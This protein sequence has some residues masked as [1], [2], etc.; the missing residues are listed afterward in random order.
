MAQTN[1]GEI[2]MGLAFPL[3]VE[4]DGR[5]AACTYEEHIKQSLRT[6]LLTSREQR[7]MRREFGN[8]LGDYL[9]ENIGPTTAAL[10]KDEIISTVE[11]YESRV[12]IDGV[13][14]RGGQTPGT[15]NVELKYRI[16]ST[17]EADRLA[18]S[19]GR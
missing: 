9:F 8:R 2:K 19:I 14:V 1:D 15:I 16:T 10:I 6:L 12:E 3:R 18:L 17:G 4:K 13:E 5:L 7:I 11:R